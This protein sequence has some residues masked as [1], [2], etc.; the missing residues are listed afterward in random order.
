[1]KAA[2]HKH[3]KKKQLGYRDAQDASK[4]A[5]EELE[6]QEEQEKYGGRHVSANLINVPAPVNSNEKR[7]LTVETTWL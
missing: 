1:M 4:H 5:R 3:V 2:S 6:P 7:F